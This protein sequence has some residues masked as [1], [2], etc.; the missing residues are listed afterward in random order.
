MVSDDQQ[1]AHV[2]RGVRLCGGGACRG[3]CCSEWRRRECW[4]AAG[5]GIEGWSEARMHAG[6]SARFWLPGLWRPG[7]TIGV[8]PRWCHFGGQL[9][10]D[11]CCLTNQGE[12]VCSSPPCMLGPHAPHSMQYAMNAMRYDMHAMLHAAHAM[13]CA[14]HAAC[15][16]YVPHCDPD[17]LCVACCMPSLAAATR[18]ISAC[19]MH[20]APDLRMAG[21]CFAWRMARQHAACR[22]RRRG[23]HPE[24]IMIRLR[25]VAHLR[26]CSGN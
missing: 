6:T 25:F 20:A 2:S 24:T 7:V 13:C 12:L 16:R 10:P 8:R 5:S 15:M 26:L 1:R 4:P 22:M 21:M 19:S 3:R 18:C 11:T 14:C 23:D 17:C 9:R